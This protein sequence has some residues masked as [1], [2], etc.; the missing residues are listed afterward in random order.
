MASLS[1]LR[2]SPDLPTDWVC[3]VRIRLLLAPP[4]YEW[5]LS[6]AP[7]L[8]TLLNSATATQQDAPEHTLP[9]LN[10]HHALLQFLSK[11]SLTPP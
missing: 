4:C 1:H 3:P 6:P 11:A 8:L 5:H 10:A 7:S 2:V 9:S